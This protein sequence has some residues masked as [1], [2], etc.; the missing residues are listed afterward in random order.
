MPKKYSSRKELKSLAMGFAEKNK[1]S[2]RTIERFMIEVDR[3][4]SHGN[5]SDIDIL[6]KAFQSCKIEGDVKKETLECE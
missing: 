2:E 6:V 1:L 5:L 3:L 4:K